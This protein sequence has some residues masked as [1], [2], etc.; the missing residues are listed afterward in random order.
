M[1][2]GYV[3]DPIFLKHTKRGHPEGASR[4]EAI[5]AELEATGLLSALQR[6]PSRAATPDELSLI[7][8][9][10]YIAEVKAKSQSG[11]GY[12]D[13]DT[14]VTPDTYAAATTAAAGTVDL[15][16]AALDGVVDNGFALVRPPGH[17]ALYFQGMGFCVFNNIVLAA[18][19]AQKERG[20]ERVAI[21]DFDVHHG[22]GTQPM[23][24]VDPTILFVS[25]HQYPFYP[26]TGGVEEIGRRAGAGFTVN[27][28]LRVGVGDAGF[29][30]LYSEIVV[31]V[32]R[33]FEPQ[34]ILVSAGYDAHWSDPLA[35]LGLSLAGYTWISQTLAG[36]AADVCDGK[37]VFVLEGGYNLPVL[38]AGVANSI[39]AL[40]GRDDMAD[41]IGPSQQES[42]DLTG[43]IAQVK[44]IHRL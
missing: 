14:Y 19:V 42:P 6:I 30:A 16:L 34:L 2:T 13:M 7:H 27:L 22:N 26:G 35:S 23:T 4:L 28:P 18:K 40:M 36:L 17:H 37:I 5:M 43:Y 25:T 15:T 1:T 3:Y 32:V 10:M 12:L 38:S 20:I 33:R 31:P 24:E 11:G 9:P 21:V 8:D 41:P 44:S 29:M 39:R